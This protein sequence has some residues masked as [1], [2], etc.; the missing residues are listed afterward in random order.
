MFAGGSVIQWLR[1][2]LGILEKASDSEALAKTVEDS[3]GVVLVPAFSG[4]GAPHWD[5]KAGPRS[6]G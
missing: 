1:D 5:A 2:G 6:S 4:L 3:G